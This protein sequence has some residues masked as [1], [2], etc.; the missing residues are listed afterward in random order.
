ML[1]KWLQLEEDAVCQ[2]VE[3]DDDDIEDEW[4]EVLEPGDQLLLLRK[5][6]SLLHSLH[7]KGVQLSDDHITNVVCELGVHVQESSTTLKNHEF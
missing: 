7:D 2:A 4:V 3:D 1:S 6:L 5:A